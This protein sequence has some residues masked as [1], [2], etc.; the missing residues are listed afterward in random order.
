MSAETA[1]S[2]I[3]IE[4]IIV[5]ALL[6]AIVWKIENWNATCKKFLHDKNG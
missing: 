1:I 4:A 3:Q 2:I 6:A 5:I